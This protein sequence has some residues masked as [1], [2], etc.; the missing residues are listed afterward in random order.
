M[1]GMRLYACNT[2]II[3]TYLHTSFSYLTNLI[4]TANNEL[5]KNTLY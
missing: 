1:L 3:I 2:I 4:E 5:D